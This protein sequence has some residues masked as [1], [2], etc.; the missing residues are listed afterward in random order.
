MEIALADWIRFRDKLAS[1]SDKASEEML[2]WIESKGGYANINKD[3]LISRAYALSTKYGKGAASLADQMYDEVAALSKVTVPAAEVAE[4]ASYGEIAKAINGVTKKLTTD[5]NVSSVVGRYVKRTGADTTLKNARRDGAQFAWVPGGD[6][7]A[8]CATLASRGWQYMSASALKGGHA[9]HIHAHCMCTY[10]VRFDN[11]TK[12][13][14]YDPDKYKEMYD[15]ADGSTPQQKI[16]SM[17][18]IQYQENKDK[19]NAQKR[20]NY[21]A[22]NNK[23]KQTGGK[24]TG[25]HRYIPDKNEGIKG[26]KA[27]EQYELYSK[28]DDSELIAKNTGFTVEEIQQIRSHV[29]FEKHDLDDG[30]KRFDPDYDMAVAWKRL[31]NG[32]YLPRDITLL[33]HELLESKLEKEYNI[34]AREAHELTQEKYNWAKQLMKETNG[35]GE[36]NGLL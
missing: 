8:F 29:F 21:A 1:M 15:S 17:R 10:M 25:G 19:I 14:G 35:K 27:A 9:E 26:I 23:I 2:S 7:C 12:I 24:I 31:Q 18:R 33:R 3:A 22:K 5:K 16:N 28:V 4:T 36:P 6:A 30:Y 20:A 32:D 13:K 34:T 11:N